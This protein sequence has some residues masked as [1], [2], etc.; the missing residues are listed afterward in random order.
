MNSAEVSAWQVG[1]RAAKAGVSVET[2]VRW[3]AGRG[4]TVFPPEEAAAMERL[5]AVDWVKW[6]SKGHADFLANG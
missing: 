6:M 1:A 3:A 4:P 5:G 2:V